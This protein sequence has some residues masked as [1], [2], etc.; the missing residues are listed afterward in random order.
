MEEE[1]KKRTRLIANS[2]I[3]ISYLAGPEYIRLQLRLRFNAN[4]GIH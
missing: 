4:R 3:L 2:N 1:G